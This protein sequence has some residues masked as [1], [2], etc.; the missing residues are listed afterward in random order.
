MRARYRNDQRVPI[1]KTKLR[2]FQRKRV[3]KQRV[4][5]KAQKKTWQE[6]VNSLNARKKR[7]GKFKKV[8]GNYKN[9]IVLSL[10]K[11][12]KDDYP[13]SRDCK[14]FCRLLWKNI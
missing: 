9:R 8:N 14:D 3:I 5:K 12:R 4:F 13:F 2:S 7:W 1:D 10:V 11:R 6:F